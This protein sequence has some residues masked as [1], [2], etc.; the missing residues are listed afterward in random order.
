MNTEFWG[1]IRSLLL[2]EFSFRE[3]K[4]ILGK[5]GID[6]TML[7]HLEQRSGTNS[8]SSTK[9]ELLSAAESQLRDMDERQVM[10]TAMICIEEML[11]QEPQIEGELSR[12]LSRLDWNVVEGNLVPIEIFDSA[13]LIQIPDESNSDIVKAV[14]RLRDGDLSGALSACCGALDSAT[15]MIYSNHCSSAPREPSFRARIVKSIEFIGVKEQL[16]A[17]LREIGWDDASIK[18]L[19]ENLTGSLNQAA[20][21]MQK[22][23]SDMGDVHGTKPV[24]SALVYDSI[25]WSLLLLRILGVGVGPI[26]EFPNS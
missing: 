1:P 20:Y 23:R 18:M 3:I 4:N 15:E 21:I 12:L 2:E 9:S 10:R 19:I 26:E 16:D 8:R 11:S 25:K 24:L 13:E 5:S 6:M 7:A 14:V 17:E 22:L